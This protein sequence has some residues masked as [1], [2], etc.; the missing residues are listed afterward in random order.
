MVDHEPRFRHANDCGPVSL[1]VLFDIFNKFVHGTKLT[2]S[3][4]IKNINWHHIHGTGCNV[5]KELIIRSPLVYNK[6]QDLVYSKQHM[7]ITDFNKDYIKLQ[8]NA[9][10]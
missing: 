8:S 7:D 5:I 6:H 3:N 4:I 2:V 1:V 10:R 9:S